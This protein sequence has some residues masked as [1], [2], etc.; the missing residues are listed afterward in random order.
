MTRGAY[1]SDTG[2]GSSNNTETMRNPET[3]DAAISVNGLRPEANN[4]N[5]DGVDNNESL[6]N[7]TV[8]ITPVE[9]M[10]QFRVTN[11]VAPAEFGRAGGAIMQDSIKSG[12]NHYHGSVFDFFRDGI[13]NSNPN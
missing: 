8:L 11:S 9:N 6:V 3:G 1:G 10:D 2:G 5:L 12:T 4:F 7:S 13:F